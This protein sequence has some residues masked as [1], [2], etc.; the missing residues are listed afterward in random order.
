MRVSRP[1]TPL[2]SR[3]G[4]AGVPLAAIVFAF[5]AA[6]GIV[7]F[8][9][10]PGHPSQGEGQRLVLRASPSGGPVVAPAPDPPASSGSASAA[11]AGAGRGGPTSEPVGPGPPSNLVT[12]PDQRAPVAPRPRPTEPPRPEP[13]P[14]APARPAS[15]LE[16]VADVVDASTSEVARALRAMT[17][18]L[19]RVVE[20][21]SPALATAAAQTGD[22]LG[23]AL[24]DTES[25][26]DDLLGTPAE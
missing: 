13:K 20:P 1:F 15:P 16:P 18:A 22:G 10:W 19:A 7:A 11:A 8:Q 26:L 6:S 9:T 21:V 23:G 24:E 17:A 25:A 3:L 2:L 4:I 14:A 12:T 5:A